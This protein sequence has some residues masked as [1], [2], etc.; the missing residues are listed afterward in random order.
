MKKLITIILILAMLLPAAALA[1]SYSPALNMSMDDFIMKYN[2][3]QAALN[4]PF[5]LLEKPYMWTQWNGYS[6]AWFHAEKDNKVTLL[7]MT[8]DP[9]AAQ[10]L[11]S[12]LDRIEISVADDK[13]LIPLI[14]VTNRC[15]GIFSYNIFGTPLSGMR[16][17]DII[18][19]Y[20]E[21]NY[22]E[23]GYSSYVSID[24][25]DKIALVLFY[26]NGYVFQIVPMEEVK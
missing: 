24:E 26:S 4:A 9:S 13:N 19:Y 21:N 25:D 17:S 2:S 7:L 18:C 5:V 12:G 16:I 15:T 20:Y 11:T 10:M 22:R 23:K 1:E 3:V 14:G 6:V 8:K